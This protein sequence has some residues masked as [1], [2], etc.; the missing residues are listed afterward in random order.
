MNP[1]DS[2]VLHMVIIIYWLN[3]RFG[4]IL[5]ILELVVIYSYGYFDRIVYYS[6][7]KTI[8]GS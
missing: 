2:P 5:R 1:G 6:L 8:K 3:F 4:G 7:Y